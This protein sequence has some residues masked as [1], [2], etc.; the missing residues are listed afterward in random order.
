M[1]LYTLT[2]KPGSERY[3]IQVGWTPHCA[4]FATVVDFGW[5]A[6]TDPDDEPDSVQLRG[7]VA[8]PTDVLAAVAPYADIP[9]GLAEQL[10]ADKAAHPPAPITAATHRKAAPRTR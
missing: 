7:D 8:D 3:T 9:D 1:S 2:P 5:D 10:R 6:V 4:F